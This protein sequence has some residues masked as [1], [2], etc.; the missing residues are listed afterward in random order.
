MIDEA[1]GDGWG[2][3]SELHLD[4]ETE[5]VDESEAGAE[6]G[7]G[8]DVEDADLILPD[9]LGPVPA[10]ATG[11]EGYFVP[12]TKGVCPSTVWTNNSQ[13]VA[14]HITAGS[15]ET[16]FRLLHDQVHCYF[17]IIFRGFIL[18]ENKLFVLKLLFLVSCRFHLL[19]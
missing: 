11:E 4:D 18:F 15:F 5:Q 19:L 9:D 2:I 16:A 17:L 14:D 3:D 10:A 13:L 1:G 12:P 7:P 6:T 8:W